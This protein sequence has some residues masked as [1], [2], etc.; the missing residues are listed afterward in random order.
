MSLAY[1]PACDI[2]TTRYRHS[3]D[4]FCRHEKGGEVNGNA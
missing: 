3:Q 2:S 1:C 4:R